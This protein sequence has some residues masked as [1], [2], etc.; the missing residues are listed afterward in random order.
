MSP[1]RLMLGVARR[2]RLF[3]AARATV[4]LPLDAGP[5]PIVGAARK[6]FHG[7]GG[8]SSHRDLRVQ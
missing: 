4:G 6:I 2:L 7:G 8:Q 5:R 3:L 1:A